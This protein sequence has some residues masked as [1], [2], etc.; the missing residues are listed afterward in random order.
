MNILNR[1]FKRCICTAAVVLACG[2]ST[3]A[4]GITTAN[5][6]FKTVSEK[7]ATYKDYQAKVEIMVGS[8]SMSASVIY[9]APDKMRMDFTNP[10]EQTIVYDGKTLICY[11]PDSA[12]V[13]TQDA[14][15]AGGSSANAANAATPEGLALLRR[16]YTVSY[17]KGQEAVPLEDDSDEM[18]V[19]LILW[20]RSTSES[21]KNIKLAIDPET[22]RIRRIVAT[23]PGGVVYQFDFKDYEIN[24]GLTDKRF[25]YDIPSGANSYDNFLMS[26]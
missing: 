8:T 2:F 20:R 9:M 4:Q 21:F 1:V 17:E 13:L 14:T 6:F 7:Y 5:E 23:T 25:Q 10:A 16:Y 22:L 12:S 3:F 11:L 24:Q 26:E 18:V 15:G 19:K